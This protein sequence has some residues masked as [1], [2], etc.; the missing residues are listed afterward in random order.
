MRVKSVD[1]HVHG[2]LFF[3]SRRPSA[4]PRFSMRDFVALKELPGTPLDIDYSPDAKAALAEMYLNDAEGDCVPAGCQH[5]DG[6]LT[7]NANAGNPVIFTDL[8]T[9]ANYTGMSG[10][11]FN[12]KDPSTDQGCDPVFAFQWWQTNGL[13]PDGSHKIAGVLNVDLTNE[14]EIRA[15]VWL[16]ENVCFAMEL[17]DAWVN[18]SPAASGFVWDVAGAP[19]PD[20]GHF[21]VGVGCNKQGIL[22]STW[23]MIGTLTYAAIAKYCA[24][25]AG[26]GLYTVIS[27]DG[28]NRAMAKFPDGLTWAQLVSDFD[29]V[30]GTVT[31]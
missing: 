14:V 7:G 2:R 20:S 9:N 28:I 26:G 25:S 6:V 10:G 1:H 12:P 22:F 23:G 31:A 30:G 29:S 21:V 16:F 27:E 13:L 11:E 24:E 19:D 15:A 18:P 4:S 17:P 5:L 3:G 8:Q